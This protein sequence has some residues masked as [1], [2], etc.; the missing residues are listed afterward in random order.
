MYVSSVKSLAK[1]VS[2][3]CIPESQNDVY[4]TYFEE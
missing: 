1:P 4:V 3:Y 2:L